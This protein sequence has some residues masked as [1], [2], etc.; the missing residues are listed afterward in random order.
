MISYS[1]EHTHKTWKITHAHPHEHNESNVDCATATHMHHQNAA[2]ATYAIVSKKHVHRQKKGRAPA[3]RRLLLDYTLW[4]GSQSATVWVDIML[5][6]DD[7]LDKFFSEQALG[8]PPT[9]EA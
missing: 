8:E 3:N 4:L 6:P 2:D 7:V 1:G 9:V 5:H